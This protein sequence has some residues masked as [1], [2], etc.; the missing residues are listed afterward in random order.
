MNGGDGTGSLWFACARTLDGRT[1]HI[2]HHIMALHTLE[3]PLLQGFD[4]PPV[5]LARCGG[6]IPVPS[7]HPRCVQAPL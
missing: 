7:T 5:G 4:V 2:G 1:R 6:K 3:Q